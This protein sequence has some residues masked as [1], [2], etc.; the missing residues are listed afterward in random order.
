[1][2]AGRYDIVADQGSTLQRAFKY[3]DPDGVP[4]DVSGYTA[5]M[6]VR[7][8]YHSGTTLVSV[9][10]EGSAPGITLGSTDG[11]ITVVVSAAVMADIPAGVFVYDLEL[12]D[13][14][15]VVSKPVRGQ[16]EVRPE[17]TR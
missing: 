8:T 3:L 15:G 17:V 4:F 9:S 7:E 16:F 2:L 6:E 1:M 11:L 13:G 5:A 14:V 12:V 10:S